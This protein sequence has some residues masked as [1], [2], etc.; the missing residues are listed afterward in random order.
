[1]AGAHNP[2]RRSAYKRPKLTLVSKTEVPSGEQGRDLP[3]GARHHRAYVGAAEGYDISGALQFNILTFLGLR[4]DH[5]LLDIGCGSLRGG[6]LS[7]SYLEPERYYGIEPEEWLIEEGIANEVGQDLIDLKRPAFSNDSTF[8][9]T[10]FG[11]QFDFILAQSIFSHASRS[12]IE[13]CLSQAK[14]VMAPNA[15]FAATFVQGEQDYEGDGWV[16]PGCVSYSLERMT[17]LAEEQGLACQTI[18]W[19]HPAQ[20]TWVVYSHSENACRIPEMGDAMKL[21]A[22][23]NELKYA[24]ARL[25]KIESHPYVRLGMKVVGNPLYNRLRETTNRLRGAA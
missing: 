22:L 17:A 24:K 2:E 5:Y 10:T 15:L 16:Y 23:E 1:M 12:Q 18:E 4:Q 3:I 7:M 25:A 6:R 11:R 14:Q 13:R 20:Q 21:L 8:T 19:P 9:L